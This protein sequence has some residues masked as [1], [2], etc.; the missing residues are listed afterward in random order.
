MS[1]YLFNPT[2]PCVYTD[3]DSGI[4]QN[5]LPYTAINDE[6][7]N[8]KLEQ[9][10]D[11]G[12]FVLDKVYNLNTPNGSVT[13]NKGMSKKLNYLDFIDLYKG[14]QLDLKEERWVRD[15]SNGIIYINEVDIHIS[16]LYTKRNKIF[17]KGLWVDTEP[18]TVNYDNIINKPTL[19]NFSYENFLFINEYRLYKMIYRAYINNSLPF[20]LKNELD[21]FF[22]KNPQ[23]SAKTLVGYSFFK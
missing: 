2:N 3:T 20:S 23:L 18:I 12:L 21:Q 11:N 6:L 7:G 14:K 15:V 4:F 16:N 8:W 5:E 19:A 22:K 13:K 10:V 9:K 1:Q 17:N